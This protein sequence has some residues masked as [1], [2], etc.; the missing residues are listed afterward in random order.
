M[1]KSHTLRFIPFISA[2][3]KAKENR[4]GRGDNHITAITISLVD[5]R[6]RCQWRS[7]QLGALINIFKE[8][9]S[10]AQAHE[11]TY[12]SLKRKVRRNLGN[13]KFV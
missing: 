7:I 12:V 6:L 4:V 2:A 11:K 5:I 10:G 8:T 1:K 13:V 9:K 3:I